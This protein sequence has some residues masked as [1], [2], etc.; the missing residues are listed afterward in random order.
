MH[1]VLQQVFDSWSDGLTGKSTAWCQLHPEQEERLWSAQE[2][3]EHLVLTCRST[4]RM[5]EQR[6]QR[7]PTSAHSTPVQWVLQMVMLN[8]GRMPRGSPAPIFARPDQLHWPEMSG[9]ELLNLFHQEVDQMDSLIDRCR[10]R[11]GLQR[12]AS[13]FI[14]GPM[15]PDQ[16]RRFHVIHIRHHLGQLRRLQQAVGDPIAHEPPPVRV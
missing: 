11:Y 7:G 4:S 10:H 9:V 14:L 8:F 12:V 6:L 1:P 2:I 3:V 15:R 5:L 13:H 16:W